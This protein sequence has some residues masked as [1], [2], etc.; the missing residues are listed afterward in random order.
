LSCLEVYGKRGKQ[1]L[2]QR[3]E[4]YARAARYYPWVVLL[5]LD[6]DA[7][8]APAYRRELLGDSEGPLVL[9]IAVRAIESWLISHA[10]AG[11][12]ICA[13]KWCRARRAGPGW[14]PF[15]ATG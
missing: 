1:H 15:T 11:G 13:E 8:C 10:T 9:R 5:D 3:L 14:D 12:R 7:D 4:G 6:A 2:I